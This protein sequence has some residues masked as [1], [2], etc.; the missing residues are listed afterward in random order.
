MKVQKRDEKTEELILNREVQQDEE[1]EKED[2]AHKKKRDSEVK[3]ARKKQEEGVAKGTRRST[4]RNTREAQLEARRKEKRHLEQLVNEEREAQDPA[5]EVKRKRK[6]AKAAV[7]NP[8]VMP[9]KDLQQYAKDLGL[10]TTGKR[11]KLLARIQRH[12]R[13]Q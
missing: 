8:S 12:L 7:R 5:R 4:R 11:R 13:K 3:L 6:I 9:L 10:N 1:D 2:K